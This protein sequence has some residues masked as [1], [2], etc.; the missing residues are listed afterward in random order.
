MLSTQ[1]SEFEVNSVQKEINEKKQE[2]FPEIANDD[3]ILEVENLTVHFFTRTGE[4]EAVRGID[5]RVRK[6]E[7]FGILGESG[8]GKSVTSLSILD[9]LPKRTGAVVNGKII[10]KGENVADLYRKEFRINR[11]GKK[12]KLRERRRVARSV[13]LQIQKV[14]GK[15]SM[16]FQDPLT[17]LDPL[18]KIK[19][20]MLESIMYNNIDTM[21]SRILE[22]DDIKRNRPELLKEFTGLNT[23]EFL[24][25]IKEIYGDGG[26][27]QELLLILNLNI[28]ESDKK[29]NIKKAIVE[30][31]SLNERE[32]QNLKE[33]LKQT[34]RKVFRPKNRKSLI[35]TPE[36]RIIEDEG[37]LYSTELLRFMDMPTPEKVLES[38]PHELSGGMKQRA[39][40]ALSVANNSDILIADE[41]TTALDVTTQ[42]QV[43]NLLKNLNKHL[44]LTI[45]FV[46]HDLGVMSAM[47]KDVA[48]M[49][50]GRL[51]EMGP[52]DKILANPLHPYTKGL[53]NCVITLR[54][55]KTKF[56]TIP[57]QVPSLINPPKGCAFADRCDF[58]M[59]KC[60]VI[61]PPLTVRD[62][63]SVYCWQFGS[64]TK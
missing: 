56:N 16:I 29:V 61:D 42:Y 43:L 19:S 1:N 45:I 9:L 63:R 5:F 37:F 18:Y 49:Y 25:R 48:V 40:I 27:Y 12:A 3:C 22:K 46:T 15:I 60:R 2:N 13:K 24:S 38:Y 36:E 53:L 51:C 44:D 23:N 41:P 33:K 34:R 14:R 20:Q 31:K 32:I 52:L 17:S 26:F 59:D 8:C 50:S 35:K 54:G 21:I 7:I 62:E 55:E 28:T 64:E 11:K 39:M 57:G 30:A 6:G 58:V 47:A 10:F 4:V